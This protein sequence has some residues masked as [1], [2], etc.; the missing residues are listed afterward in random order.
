MVRANPYDGEKEGANEHMESNRVFFSIML[1]VY[2][3]QD[4]VAQAIESVINQPYDNWELI[5]MND[6]ST[7][8][9]LNICQTYSRQDPRIQIHTHENV[10][11][12]KNRNMGFEYLSGRW[13][14]FLDHDDMI[15]GNFLTEE[16]ANFLQKCE[17]NQID[18][19]VPAR[20]VVD[21]EVKNARIE[22]VP[23]DEIRVGGNDVSWNMI[24]EFATMLYRTE[25]LTAHN[26]RF[27]ETRPEMES[28]FRHKAAFLAR[29]VLFTNQLFFGVRR[30]NPKSITNTWDYLKI[31]PVRFQ[32][33]AD[34][35]QWHINYDKDD[36]QAYLST[37]TRTIEIVKDYLERNLENKVSI[38][39][40]LENAKQLSMYAYVQA[41]T[42][43][44]GLRNAWVHLFAR[45][46][47]LSLYMMKCRQ[48]KDQ[49]PQ[50][51]KYSNSYDYYLCKANQFKTV[52]SRLSDTM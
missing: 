12:G 29:K 16:L 48:E 47:R 33:Y 44:R 19:I 3:G 52:Y 20:L 42:H 32:T 11:L 27:H 38:A 41:C 4:L 40:T 43:E 51:R 5:I 35:E 31:I 30:E 39:Q 18:L 50:M 1:P 15:L 21:Y 14:I 8:N 34:L 17:H 6:G 46:P 25:L 24:H 36:R 49:T 10:G 45:L 23:W 9:T 7:D 13:T 37:K 28:I 22:Y 26:I 2:N